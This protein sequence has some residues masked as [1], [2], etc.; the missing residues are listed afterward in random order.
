MT[1]HE[2]WKLFPVYFISIAQ[3]GFEFPAKYATV[4][5]LTAY[6]V[7]DVRLSEICKSSGE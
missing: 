1:A 6:T 7:Y 4:A 3:Y 2:M 5:E